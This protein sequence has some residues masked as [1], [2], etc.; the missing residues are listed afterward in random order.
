MDATRAR[1][2]SDPVV[3]SSIVCF[4]PDPAALAALVTA[5]APQVARVVVIDNSPGEPALDPATL[6]GAMHVR[7]PSNTGTAGGLNE[8]WRRALA[9]GATH[10]VSFDQ[11]SRPDSELVR[12]L[13]E[14]F[15]AAGPGLAAIG[16]VW[17]DSRSG[18]ALR[19]L[20]PVRFVRRHVAAPPAGR[21]EV[22]HIITSGC[23]TSAQAFRQ[24]GPFDD[25]L[26]LDYV[27]V[28]WSLRARA[29]GLSVAVAAGCRMQHTIGDRVIS[30]WGR[31]LSLH[32][33]A[34]SY[35]QVRNHLLLW[36][37]KWIPRG[38]LLSDLFQV[39][40]KLGA[41]F[42]LAPLRRQRLRCVIAGI[43]DGLRGRSGPIPA[44]T[45]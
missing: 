12:C 29:Q 44:G 4:H 2:G 16:P 22:D 25:A 6:G 23:L 14:E 1:P 36:R 11:D 37:R 35:L 31:Q 18:V 13:L 10:L 34:R 38:W 7:M 9:A 42:L 21:V 26:F 43:R 20:R 5:L 45:P 24:V 28:E 39:V 40:F 30:I 33:P 32:Q 8:A 17:R 3:W 19:V 41:L 27:D 15:A